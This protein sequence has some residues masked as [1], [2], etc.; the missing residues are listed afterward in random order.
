[1]AKW[2]HALDSLLVD[3]SLDDSHYFD[4]FHTHRDEF[5]LQMKG[6]EDKC[7]HADLISK[8]SGRVDIMRCLVD[9]CGYTYDVVTMLRTLTLFRDYYLLEEMLQKHP[10][11]YEE[12]AMCHMV[13]T[14][15]LFEECD[16][17]FLLLAHGFVYDHE[18]LVKQLHVNN[19]LRTVDL[20]VPH[21]AYII[22]MMDVLEVDSTSHLYIHVA[23]Q[24]MEIKRCHDVVQNCLH[25]YITSDVLQHNVCEFV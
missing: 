22:E 1:M 10:E 25:D 15:S 18:R 16:C 23:M 7:M 6:C 20:F 21:R 4:L 11:F 13:E 8:I 17:L 5:V 3:V 14:A 9:E 12:D 24:R 19:S 2:M